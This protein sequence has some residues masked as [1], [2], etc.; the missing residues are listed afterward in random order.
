MMISGAPS[1][2][3]EIQRAEQLRRAGQPRLAAK[4]LRSILDQDRQ[5]F[6]ANY[7]LGMLYHRNGRNDLAIPLLSQAVEVRPEVFETT[8]NLGI[9]QHEEGMLQEA[10]ANLEKAISLRPESVIARLMLGKLLTDQGMYDAAALELER[11]LALEPG[12]DEVLAQ[13]GFLEQLRGNP[14]RAKRRYIEAITINPLN[15]EVHYRLALLHERKSDRQ[16][17]QQMENAWRSQEISEPDRALVGFSLGLALDELKQFDNA[18]EYFHAANQLQAKSSDYSHARQQAFFNR[19]RQGF[20]RAF[21]DHCRDHATDDETAVFIVGLPRSGTSLVEQILASHPQVHGAGEVEYTRLFVEET[22]RLTG[23]P[24]PEGIGSIDPAVFTRL[25]K[26][27]IAKLRTHDASAVRVTDKLPHN[28]LRIGLLAAVMPKAKI[29]LCERDPMDNCLSIYQHFFS[30]AHGYSTDLGDLGNYHRLYRGL[31]DYWSE[32]LPGKIYRLGYEDLVSDTESQVRQLLAH[33]EIPFSTACLSFHETRR[34]INTP[35]AAQVRE[36]MHGR[37]VGRWKN[38][39]N[40]LQPL[41]QAL[42]REQN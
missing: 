26:S 32:L 7:A 19:H 8:I 38:Y 23:R 9:I 28:F 30:A 4:V 33:C 24:F 25:S 35:S 11:A 2:S 37:S 40:H 21:L 12:S 6:T 18:I 10:Q 3:E 29:I 41:M 1:Y 20:D 17:I 27:Y 16:T 36:P 5:H 22:Q 31:I 14:G 15:G 39:A 34:V 13:I 42:G